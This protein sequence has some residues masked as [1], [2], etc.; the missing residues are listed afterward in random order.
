M[1]RKSSYFA[2]KNVA[3]INSGTHLNTL[4]LLVDIPYNWQFIMYSF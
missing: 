1:L 4:P 2:L 3:H